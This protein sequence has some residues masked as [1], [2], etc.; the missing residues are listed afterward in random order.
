MPKAVREPSTG[1]AEGKGEGAPKRFVPA[2]RTDAIVSNCKRCARRYRDVLELRSWDDE[3]SGLKLS[4]IKMYETHVLTVKLSGLDVRI[5]HHGRYR[6]LYTMLLERTE[7]EPGY[8][9]PDESV[10]G[11]EMDRPDR[12]SFAQLLQ[13]L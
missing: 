10:C 4:L 3:S 13:S 11:N 9:T 7:E 12:L 1:M 8:A 6:N 5:Y 2:L